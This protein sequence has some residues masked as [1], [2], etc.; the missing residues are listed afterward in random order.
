MVKQWLFMKCLD[1]RLLTTLFAQTKH[2]SV[3]SEV[4]SVCTVAN[5]V[6][7]QFVISALMDF[8]TLIGPTDPA[9]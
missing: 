3:C 2:W 1:M 6:V 5:T 9:V 4:N 7:T 8:T